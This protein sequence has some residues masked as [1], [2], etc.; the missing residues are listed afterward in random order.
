MEK[1]ESTKATQ[2]LTRIG[3]F[4]ITITF[5]FLLAWLV[6]RFMPN[7]DKLSYT[8]S[9]SE[10]IAFGTML[11][12]ALYAFAF[13]SLQGAINKNTEAQN[14]KNERKDRNNV[15]LVL[16]IATSNL[17]QQSIE[18]I[19]T[20]AIG[21]KISEKDYTTMLSW[22]NQI[23][24]YLKGINNHKNCTAEENQNYV[25]DILEN[26]QKIREDI[27]FI[28]QHNLTENHQKGL[29]I[30]LTQMASMLNWLETQILV[31]NFEEN[32]QTPL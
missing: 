22:N 10:I 4:I 13:I 18:K 29:H 11:F 20:F 26:N 8:K 23:A 6:A 14:G 5:T 31:S 12:T 24:M 17:I 30:R 7:G 19:A 28:Y 3:L 21:E 16:S 9:L 2:T 1:N 15:F 25:G 32:K 27:E